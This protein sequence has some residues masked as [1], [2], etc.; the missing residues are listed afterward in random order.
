MDFDDHL[1]SFNVIARK[2]NVVLTAI[3]A[4]SKKPLPTGLSKKT[5]KF[6]RSLQLIGSKLKTAL[7]DKDC[8]ADMMKIDVLE[9][10]SL[11]QLYNSYGIIDVVLLSSKYKTAQAIKIP[12]FHCTMLAQ[13]ARESSMGI[14]NVFHPS[15]P[16][17]PT[18]TPHR[19][20]LHRV[21]YPAL[22]PPRRPFP[23]IPTH[24]FVLGTLFKRTLSAFPGGILGIISL[25]QALRSVPIAFAGFDQWSYPEDS[26]VYADAKG[27][28]VMVAVDLAPVLL[29]EL[30]GEVD[31]SLRSLK[32]QKVDVPVSAGVKGGKEVR[33]AQP[34]SRSPLSASLSF[35]IF[36]NPPYTAKIMEPPTNPSPR[37][38][39]KGPNQIDGGREQGRKEGRKEESKT[40][41]F[42]KPM[43]WLFSRKHWRQMLRPYFRIRPAL[44]L[45]E[46][47]V[48]IIQELIN[49]TPPAN[50]EPPAHHEELSSPTPKP[51]SACWTT[52]SA[53]VSPG[54]KPTAEANPRGLSRAVTT[55]NNRKLAPHVLRDEEGKITT[56]RTRER[57][58]LNAKG[59]KWHCSV[60]LRTSLIDTE[61]QRWI[62]T[63]KERN[64]VSE[65]S[66][67]MAPNLLEYYRHK[68]RHPASAKAIKYEYSL[69]S[70]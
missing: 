43:S 4:P 59:C 14:D 25:F 45:H 30:T 56:D 1:H 12:R 40:L 39:R 44:W 53:K 69:D 6:G 60:A 61:V 52:R 3:D 11:E 54:S 48:P 35:D 67:S 38:Q 65:H 22:R 50:L 55:Q 63:V 26:A 23:T 42:V 57:I 36:P 8:Q 31:P 46:E 70:E 34:L 10:Q 20:T 7:S 32:S 51:T 16:S 47:D 19:S 17:P 58:N 13:V 18:A 15:T 64:N 21:I 62:M 9:Q 68:A 37:A 66:H 5:E 29:G 33:V 28:A 49:A 27:V 41:T 24:P 2:H